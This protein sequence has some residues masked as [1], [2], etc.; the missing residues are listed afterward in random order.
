[1]LFVLP[2][3]GAHGRSSRRG[4]R[5]VPHL[6][7]ADL[8]FLLTSAKLQARLDILYASRVNKLMTGCPHCSRA[9]AATLGKFKSVR[10]GYASQQ[11]CSQIASC[12]C[13]CPAH[14]LAACAPCNKPGAALAEIETQSRPA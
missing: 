12:C 4:G 6:T 7:S 1:M 8:H 10:A 5:W 14:I 13:L 9:P 2:E 3:T 11:P